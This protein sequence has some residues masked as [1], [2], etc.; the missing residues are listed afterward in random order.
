VS[1]SRGRARALGNEPEF[2]RAQGEDTG[3]SPRRAE[4]Q[5]PSATTSFQGVRRRKQKG[6]SSEREA[7]ALATNEFPGAKRCLTPVWRLFV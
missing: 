2:P 3:V 7:R 4:G 1:P 5:G 6:V